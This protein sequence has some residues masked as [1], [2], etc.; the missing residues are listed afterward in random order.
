MNSKID[1]I[2]FFFIKD[3]VSQEFVIFRLRSCFHAKM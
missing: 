1:K 2:I 3:I